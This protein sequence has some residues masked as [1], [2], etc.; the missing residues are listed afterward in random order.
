[1]TANDQSPKS[2]HLQ[3]AIDGFDERLRTPMNARFESYPGS[4]RADL[5]SACCFTTLALY[6]AGQVFAR[7]FRWKE[8]AKR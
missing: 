5:G 1:M 7:A 4:Q 3:R 2:L 6:V 8:F